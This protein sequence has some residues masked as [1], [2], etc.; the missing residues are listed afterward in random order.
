MAERY[1]RTGY[2]SYFS[3]YS[4]F[5]YLRLAAAGMDKP[6]SQTDSSRVSRTLAESKGMIAWEMLAK[7]IGRGKFQRAMQSLFRENLYQRL[8]F[9]EFRKLFSRHAGSDLSWFFEQWFDREGVPDLKLDWRRAGRKVEGQIRQVGKPYRLSVPVE[10]V[11]A[12]GKRARHM[13]RVTNA[14]TRFTFNVRGQV[15]SLEL[16]PEYEVLRWTDAYRAEAEALVPHTLAV[17]AFHA[18]ENDKAIALYRAALAVK[19]SD[20]RFGLQFLLRYGLAEA[21][22]DKGDHAAARAAIDEALRTRPR[23]VEELPYAHLLR[24]KIAQKQ[25]D[26]A[27]FEQSVADVRASER[28]AGGYT[29]AA[30]LLPALLRSPPA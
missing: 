7:E 12:D 18:G 5:G 3:E 11:T 30:D 9:P 26:K 21:L 4:G 16:D 10:V 25:G 22:F 28:A 17:H 8:S 2:P 20:H 23:R 27:A 19:R 29:G 14:N 1:R 24:A 15:S 13:V 6:L